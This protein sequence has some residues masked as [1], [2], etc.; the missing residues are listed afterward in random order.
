NF[1]SKIISLT[2][3]YRLLEWFYARLGQVV[4]FLSLIFEGDGGVLWTLVFLALVI[5]L[6]RSQ[7]T[8]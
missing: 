5:T 7:V 2:W 4:R 8:P 6:I 1:L 3:F